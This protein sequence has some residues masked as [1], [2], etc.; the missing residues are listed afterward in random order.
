MHELEA[1]LVRVAYADFQE[2]FEKLLHL[3]LQKRLYYCEE[4]EGIPNK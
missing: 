2:V 3:R 4:G 1:D